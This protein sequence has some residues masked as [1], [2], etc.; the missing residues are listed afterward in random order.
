MSN[1]YF[2]QFKKTGKI[3]DFLL[4]RYELAK[5]TK[6]DYDKKRGD[7]PKPNGLPRKS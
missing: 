1:K 2:E 6:V 7:S 4:Y 5:E 3:N